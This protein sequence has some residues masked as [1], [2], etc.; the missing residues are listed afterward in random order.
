MYCSDGT[1]IEQQCMSK[2]SFQYACY[3]G[4][5]SSYACH[6]IHGSVTDGDRKG[7]RMAVTGGCVTRPWRH[8]RDE[9][10]P[11][12]VTLGGR[13]R[14]P[15]V[16]SSPFRYGMIFYVSAVDWAGFTI[17]SS[18]GC[19]VTYPGVKLPMMV[20]NMVLH[21]LRFFCLALPCPLKKVAYSNVFAR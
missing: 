12:T 5:L 18:E 7:E 4:K 2:T 20:R 13:K 14:G 9:R 19:H 11:S 6:R 10:T 3:E 16:K 8:V 17:T 15:Y 1:Q 21:R